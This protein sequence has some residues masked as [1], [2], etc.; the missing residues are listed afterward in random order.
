MV[1]GEE[2]E[3][4]TEDKSCEKG[5]YLAPG[6][7][8]C[9][10]PHIVTQMASRHLHGF[11]WEGGLVVLGW[12]IGLWYL[13]RPASAFVCMLDLPW[14]RTWLAWLLSQAERLVSVGFSSCVSHSAFHIVAGELPERAG[15][16]M[17]ARALVQCEV[18][19]RHSCWT[20]MFSRRDTWIPGLLVAEA[21]NVAARGQPP[22][23]PSGAAKQIPYF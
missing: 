8:A 9:H 23:L 7:L 15:T 3:A 2:Q 21:P 17:E 6:G 14:Q 1:V 22:S 11:S 5:T 12:H 13:S 10:L 18:M 16:W 19:R 20:R 4:V